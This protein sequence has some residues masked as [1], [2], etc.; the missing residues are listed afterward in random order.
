MQLVDSKFKQ[1]NDLRRWHVNC[2]YLFVK[3]DT[4]IVLWQRTV[5]I[6]SLLQ[7]VYNRDK[8]GECLWLFQVPTP[9][10]LC[11]STVHSIGQVVEPCQCYSESLLYACWKKQSHRESV[12]DAEK[13]NLERIPSARSVLCPVM[14][15]TWQLFSCVQ[16]TRRP[17]SR[18]PTT[19]RASSRTST[20]VQGREL[21]VQ[22]FF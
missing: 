8:Y 6:S 16:T 19:R 14:M 5:L 2:I 4:A 7:C 15:S 20:N 22:I 1:H 21:W 18:T 12:L 3:P 11:A 9:K 10:E 17:C 13:V